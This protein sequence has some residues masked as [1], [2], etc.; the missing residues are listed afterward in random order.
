MAAILE[1]EFHHCEHAESIQQRFFRI[2]AL[3]RGSQ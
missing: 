1:R 3:L 2:A